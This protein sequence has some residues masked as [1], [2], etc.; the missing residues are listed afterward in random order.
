MTIDLILD[1][2]NASFSIPASVSGVHRQILSYIS[3]YFIINRLN[4]DAFDC[5]DRLC[6]IRYSGDHLVSQ[7]FSLHE[8]LSINYF[9]YSGPLDAYNRRSGSDFYLSLGLNSD[10]PHLDKLFL[11]ILR[12]HFDSCIEPVSFVLMTHDIDKT[13]Y[14]E[15]I[16][17]L[18]KALTGDLLKRNKLYLDRLAHFFSKKFI[19]KHL[20]SLFY[21]T[22]PRVTFILPKKDP[23]HADYDAVSFLYFLFSSEY[24]SSYGLHYSIQS[25][26][27]SSSIDSEFIVLSQ[28]VSIPFCR[29]HYLNRSPHTDSWLSDSQLIDLTPYALDSGGFYI[30][31]SYPFFIANP[32]I[33]G[34]IF[35]LNTTFMDVTFHFMRASFGRK[36]ELLS[37]YCYNI[38]QF[39]GIFVANWHNTSFYWGN[40]PFDPF[41]YGF[42]VSFLKCYFDD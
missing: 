23:L 4:I 20:N 6:S 29:A 28:H 33:P 30:P 32:N 36:K 21:D 16:P 22:F 7:F 34:G 31:S 12:K 24:V 35:S 13:S 5:Y 15:T 26:E 25:S 17:L 2:R 11:S 41:N 27:E 14:V 39:G 38:S 10:E 37:S 40:W 18:F 3:S 9:D 19:H 42:L 8:L 1:C